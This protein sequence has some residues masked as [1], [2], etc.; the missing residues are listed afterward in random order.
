MTGTFAATVDGGPVAAA[1]K[2]T[3]GHG[4][5]SSLTALL[6][7]LITPGLAGDTETIT[8][9]SAKLG[10]ATLTA[11]AVSYT[12]PV[13]GPDVVTYTATDQLGEVASGSVTVTVDTGPKLTGVTVAKVGHGQTVKA[14]TVLPGITGDQV[15]LATLTA[16]LGTLSL[17]NG[18]VSY[19]A[20]NA[21]GPDS[22]GY[23]VID[24]YG[25]AVTGTF[26]TQVDPG[27]TAGTLST[28]SKLGV[29]T[30][31]TSAILGVDK[32]GLPGDVLSLSG[33]GTTGTLGAVSF[34]NGRIS[35]AAIGAALAAAA[36]HGGTTDSFAY[37]VQDQL[38]ERVGG[39]VTIQVVM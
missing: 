5:T 16:G 14:A 3:I 13:T 22:I 26:V 1:G 24:Q 32:V 17:A 37:T 4:K 19:T 15:S 20:P 39:L 30:D 9:V 23:Q 35:Y 6:S 36:G 31:L 38:G 12:A 25:E 18:V 29:T 33:I 8:A 27:P 34:A 21:G 7:S 11:G 28:T 10:T 2:V